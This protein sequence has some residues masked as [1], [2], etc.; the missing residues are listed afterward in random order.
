M[1]LTPSSIGAAADMTD[2]PLASGD[3][4]ADRRYGYGQAAAEDGDFSP[5]RICSSR[6]WSAP[7]TGRRR[8]LRSATRA[9]GSG[10][11]RPP[12]TPS[13]R[14][15]R[16]RSVRRAR[17]RAARLALI[18]GAEAPDALP[19]AYVTPAFRRLRAAFRG[20]PR[21][22]ARYRGPVVI[23]EA[24]DA[25]APGRR[26]ARALDL[27]CG[28]GLAGRGAPG[29]R[30][31]PDGVDLAPAMIARAALAQRLRRARD[32]RRGRAAR[33]ARRPAPST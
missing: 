12:P 8:C 10:C 32:R 33:R 28:T 5:R 17:R 22:R 14:T 11:A 25:A 6:R 18:G 2:D 29:S 4:I 13:A 1:T 21:R 3:L 15:S 9:N 31:P 19:R 30:R 16:R 23:L 7:R 27:G 20:P 26:F 24:L